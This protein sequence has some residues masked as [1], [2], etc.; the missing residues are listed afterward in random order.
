VRRRGR[1]GLTVAAF[2]ALTAPAACDRG[3]GGLLT[4]ISPG[5][6]RSSVIPTVNTSTLEMR[7]T[8]PQDGASVSGTVS[9]SVEAKVRDVQRDRTEIFIG[10]SLV[11]SSTQ[12]KFSYAWRTAGYSGPQTITAVGWDVEGGSATTS[13]TVSLPASITGGASAAE[14]VAQA[15]ALS[16][17]TVLAGGSATGTVTL[18]APAPAGGTVVGLMSGTTAAATVSP[19][20]TVPA[21]STT[22]TFPVST[23]PVA[24]ATGVAIS[25]SAG[26][27]T[28]TATL[29]VLPAGVTVESIV[30]APTLVASGAE[31]Q[32]TVTLT[33]PAPDSGAVVVLSSGNAAA[34]AVPPSVT[35]P[36]GAT[37]VSIPLTAGTVATATSVS[38]SAA[39][40]GVTRSATLFVNPPAPAAGQL[41][42]LTISP[43]NLVGG[44]TAQGVVTLGAATTSDTK[45]SLT[46][47]NTSVAT[48]PASVTVPAGA[49]S[50]TF[51]VTTL[52][53][54]TGQ[55]QFSLISGQ[56][57]GVTQSASITTIPVPSGPAPVSVTFSS[58]TVGGGG[59]VTGIVTFDT[60]GGVIPTYTSSRPDIVQV[61]PRQ[62]DIIWSSTQH[63]FAVTTSPVS[64]PTVVTITVTTCCG[65]TATGTLTVTPTPPPPPDRVQVTDARWIPGG[66]GGTLV[67]RATSTSPTAILRVFNVN[68]QFQL[69]VLQPVGG[70]KYQGQASF[71]GGATNP[72]RIEL[73]SNLGG[74]TTATVRQ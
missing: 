70:G 25:A 49:T 20:V 36:A 29:W 67:V 33:G 35:V 73:R 39:Y 66:R 7:I 62:G 56:A 54:T 63:A 50:A 9:V 30:L 2:L 12:E 41:A 3:P 11:A 23:H 71:G 5:S 14:P 60:P 55:G 43:N 61:P 22:V 15:M 6:A 65:H 37:S 44:E 8:N 74:S 59:P 32:A 26:G 68:P 16:P 40:G 1:F 19:T 51:A 34:A 4:D 42:S 31:S 47:T 27:V 48:V 57:G 24:A 72:G 52:V 38:I 69:L 28:Q 13:V 46:S 45:V 58:A 53:N 64:T 21:G 17:D 10:D 18:A